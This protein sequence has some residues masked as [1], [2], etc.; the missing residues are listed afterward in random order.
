MLVIAAPVASVCA[1]CGASDDDHSASGVT[2]PVR[3]LVAPRR[4]VALA[5]G[6]TT[7][8]ELCVLLCDNACVNSA[9][10][11]RAP[12]TRTFVATVLPFLL[13]VLAVN[14]SSVLGGFED[15]G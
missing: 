4:A 6:K 15:C 7:H 1:R 11:C 9:I 5:P 12:E 2:R 3:K 14:L 8:R 13:T 10:S